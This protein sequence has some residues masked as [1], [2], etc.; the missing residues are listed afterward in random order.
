MEFT[1]LTGQAEIRSFSIIP[2]GLAVSGSGFV[3]SGRSDVVEDHKIPDRHFR[4]EFE[5][6]I[7][8]HEVVPFRWI[9]AARHVQSGACV[10]TELATSG[11]I[12]RV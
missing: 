4:G 6:T 2:T 10:A 11:V 1:V 8:D 9:E 7:V 3:N 5:P 12:D